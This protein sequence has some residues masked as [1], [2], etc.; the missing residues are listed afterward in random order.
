MKKLLIALLVLGSISSFANSRLFCQSTN[1][2]F[3]SPMNDII[4]E[5]GIDNS[6]NTVNVVKLHHVVNPVRIIPHV[7]KTFDN[8]NF[9][10]YLPEGRIVIPLDGEISTY[11]DLNGYNDS[12]Q[13]PI[14]KCTSKIP[15]TVTNCM[16]ACFRSINRN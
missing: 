3:N 11:N 15:E 16:G 9:F 2:G 10:I 1:N 12:E 6:M 8:G 14:L 5:I 7:V 13:E 4:L